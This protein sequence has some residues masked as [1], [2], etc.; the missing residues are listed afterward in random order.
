[1]LNISKVFKIE[2]SVNRLKDYFD[3][4]CLLSSTEL[5]YYMYSENCISGF[6]FEEDKLKKKMVSIEQ[7]LLL[8]SIVRSL[9]LF[10]YFIVLF[11]PLRRLFVN[12]ILH[13]IVW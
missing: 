10:V 6:T 11:V 1:M 8:C 7:S 5:Y 3:E 13:G 4:I 2:Y 12:G 9:A